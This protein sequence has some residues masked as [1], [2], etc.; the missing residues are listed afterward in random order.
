MIVP[1]MRRV[2]DYLHSRGKFCDLHSCGQLY[3][4]VPNII[5]AGWDSWTPQL[6]NDTHKIYEEYGDKIIIAVAPALF[7]PATAT[8]EEQRAAAKDYAAKFCNP[9]KPSTFSLY[10]SLAL[11]HAYREELYIQSRKKYGGFI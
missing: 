5:A 4:Q 9:G 1:Y 7:D 2:T 10:G 6:M 8:E 11:T 3:K